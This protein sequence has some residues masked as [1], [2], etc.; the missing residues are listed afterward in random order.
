MVRLIGQLAKRLGARLPARAIS[1]LLSLRLRN[2]DLAEESGRRV[3][4]AR[5]HKKRIVNL[6][7]KEK[8]ASLFWLSDGV[9]PFYG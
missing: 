3:K 8:K 7:K 1:C 2:L 5:D 6:S 9:D 4:M